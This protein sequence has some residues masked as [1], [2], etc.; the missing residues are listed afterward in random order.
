MTHGTPVK[1]KREQGR[2]STGKNENFLTLTKD[3]K[4]QVKIPSSK[5]TQD[6]YGPGPP[7]QGPGAMGSANDPGLCV[8]PA[9]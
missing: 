2:S 8:D 4:P 7:Y 3:I 5:P 1:G 9:V 6:P